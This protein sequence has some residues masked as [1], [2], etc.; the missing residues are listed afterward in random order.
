MRKVASEIEKISNSWEKERFR[1]LFEK[2]AG[3]FEEVK[4]EVKEF[5]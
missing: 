4:G 5:V 2:L 3:E 1:E